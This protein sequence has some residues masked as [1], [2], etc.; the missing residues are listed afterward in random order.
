MEYLIV[1]LLVLCLLIVGYQLIKPSGNTV[2]VFRQL[3]QTELKEN[4][5]ELS[6]ALKDNRE[7]LSNGLERLTNKLEEKL[8]QINEGLNSNAKT[9]RLIKAMKK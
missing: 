2:E 3:I 6:L 7:E 5:I 1:A 9:N 8:Y 4:R